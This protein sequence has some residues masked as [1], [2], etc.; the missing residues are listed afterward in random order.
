MD[1]KEHIFIPQASITVSLTHTWR[2]QS[3]SIHKSP[4]T[5]WSTPLLNAMYFLVVGSQYPKHTETHVTKAAS[6]LCKLRQADMAETKPQLS[7]PCLGELALIFS[8]CFTLMCW[9]DKVQTDSKKISSQLQRTQAFCI[10]T[11]MAAIS[12]SLDTGAM[13]LPSFQE[14]SFVVAP[15]FTGWGYVFVSAS[16]FPSPAYLLP[17]STQSLV[18]DPNLW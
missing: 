15:C 1:H 13:F 12:L 18:F 14:S 8:F 11:K 4:N 2:C 17:F 5:A 16:N 6:A 9:C 3:W 7:H 10:S